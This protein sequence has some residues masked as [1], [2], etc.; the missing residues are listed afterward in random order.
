MKNVYFQKI[1]LKMLFGP[2]KIAVELNVF[3]KFTLVSYPAPQVHC[4][5]CGRIFC[6]ACVAH[7]VAAGPRAAPARVCSVCLT[8]LQPHRAPY[9][10]TRPP[11]TP[12]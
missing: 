6:G 7:S 1:H 4:R 2:M 9:F 12:D 8:L 3:Y 5:H 10:S 11:N